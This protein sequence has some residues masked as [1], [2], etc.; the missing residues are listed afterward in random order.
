MLKETSLSI[1]YELT[2]VKSELQQRKEIEEE[3]RVKKAQEESRILATRT[4][5]FEI[6][7]TFTIQ[8]VLWSTFMNPERM[9]FA[10]STNP[11]GNFPLSLIYTDPEALFQRIASEI[12]NALR[13]FNQ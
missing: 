7:D 12:P 5:N 10:Q 13:K 6:D 1:T 8:K 4:F 9:K 3:E 11:W 2:T